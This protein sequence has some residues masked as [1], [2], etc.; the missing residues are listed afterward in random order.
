MPLVVILLLLM[1]GSV[2]AETYY[3]NGSSGNVGSTCSTARA[4]NGC[5]GGSCSVRSITQGKGCLAG[6][7]TLRIANGDYVGQDLY[8]LP[9]GS[10][11]NPTRIESINGYPNVRLLPPWSDGIPAYMNSEDHVTFT[12]LILDGENHRGG[13]EAGGWWAFFSDPGGT[14]WVG[15]A[16]FI[17]FEY[18]EVVNFGSQ[19]IFGIGDGWII[20]HNV[21]HNI[22]GW[23]LDHDH[24]LYFSFWNSTV[25]SNIIANCNFHAIQNYTSASGDKYHN[26]E[27]NVFSSNTFTGSGQG[28]ITHGDNATWKNNIFYNEGIRSGGAPVL[29][30]NSPGSVIYNNSVYCGDIGPIHGSGSNDGGTSLQG[31]LAWCPGQ[32]VS[33]SA[34]NGTAINNRVNINPSWVDPDNGDLHL[35]AG[36]SAINACPTLTGVSPDMDGDARTAP[37]DCGADERTTGVTPVLTALVFT[38]QPSSEVVNVAISPAVVVQAQDQ[39]G[40][41]YTPAVSITLS[42]A[43]GPGGAVLSGTT[44]VSTSGGNASFST[45]SLN[46]PGTYILQAAVGGLTTTS[47]SFAITPTAAQAI[48]SLVFLT[49]PSNT[50]AGAAMSPAVEVEILDQVGAPYTAA[51]VAIEMR[52]FQNVGGVVVSN[53]TAMTNSSTGRAL[54]SALSIAVVGTYRFRGVALVGGVDVTDTIT[55]EFLISTTPAAAT[56]LTFAPPHGEVPTQTVVGALM[57]PAVKVAVLDQFGALYTASPVTVTLA[58]AA[59]PGG[60]TLSGTLIKGTSGGVAMFDNLSLN[61][62]AVGYSL[63]ATAPGG[64]TAVTSPPFLIETGLPQ[65]T[66]GIR[67]TRGLLMNR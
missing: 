55:G 45:L 51:P 35:Q 6:G 31:N 39:S 34:A 50:V 53:N 20:R 11:G 28:V 52:I 48:T 3:V 59:N 17:T 32:T 5:T 14:S 27:N 1:V 18:G 12:G 19:G 25:H 22:G 62:A 26:P 61:V 2:S 10:A 44:T 37:Y 4:S 38:G 13:N 23:D 60:A 9:S 29:R 43:S 8:N 58:L 49:Q 40:N 56:T 65:G 7:D 33:V 47:N 63:Q 46:L 36:S 24:C 16:T 64:V 54:F 66:V 21:I 42:I 41:P 57:T 67:Q 15:A 30:S